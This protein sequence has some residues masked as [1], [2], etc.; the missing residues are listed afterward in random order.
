MS[1]FKII[2]IGIFI[3]GAV[4]GL[5]VFSGIISV[6][7]SSTTTVK[8][9]V[10]IWG[11]LDQQAMTGFMSDFNLTS[12]DIHATYVQKDAATFDSILVEAIAS[13][14][15]PDLVL[16]PDNLIWRMQDKLTHIQFSSLP[17][18]TFQSTF[19]D[20]ANIFSVSD[21][22]IAVPWVADPLVLYY[23]RDLIS[24][25]GL[26]QP[27][28]TWQA[29]VDSIP[30]LTKKQSDLTLTQMGAAL[31]TYKNI[32]HPK[33]LLAL[34][35]MQSGSPF[36]TSTGGTLGVH[37]GATGTTAEND[38]AIAAMNFYMGFS[39]PLKQ[40]YT[41]NNGEPLD[42]DAFIQSSLAYYFGTASELPA[43]RAQNP[44]LNFG[45]TIPPRGATG[46]PMT[47]GRSYGF[48]IPLATKNQL[49]AYTATTLLANAANE[50]DL[51]T[52][53][54]TTLAL[55]PSR[56]DVLAAKPKDDPY[57][58]FLYNAVLV[59]KPWLDPNPTVSSQIFSNL[60]RDI[61][62]S[63]LD[64]GSALGKAAA[65]LGALGAKI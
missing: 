1:N 9:T 6:G 46:T 43:I 15:P 36:I 26:A 10:T 13:G 50:T 8:G 34:L 28:A 32:A 21:G 40:V 45:I 33:D 47:T 7:S 30:L 51:A 54:A 41:W 64:V 61:N 55:I 62:S 5:L 57:L 49:L 25:A 11:T 3:A 4:F 37:F 19:A 60:I 38:A 18:A 20:S 44:N 53:S 24:A 27:P 23:N 39:D 12:Q 59:Q 56:R 22:T 31:G 29:F 2:F 14:T 65:Q 17:L 52:K 63:T 42:R 16:L 35:F 58:G 48:A